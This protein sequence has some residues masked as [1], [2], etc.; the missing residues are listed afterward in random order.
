VIGKPENIFAA[1]GKNPDPTTNYHIELFS[2]PQ[3]LHLDVI[4]SAVPPTMSLISH[5]NLS[6]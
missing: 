2:F 4:P 1:L 5:Y 6:G 3:S